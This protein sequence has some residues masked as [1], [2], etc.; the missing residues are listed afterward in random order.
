MATFDFAN[1]IP[2]RTSGLLLAQILN[3][4]FAAEKSGYS[5]GDDSRA[6]LTY[7]AGKVWYNNQQAAAGVLYMKG[8]GNDSLPLFKANLNTRQ[9]RTVNDAAL[10]SGWQSVRNGEAEYVSADTRAFSV[11]ADGIAFGSR[12]AEYTIDARGRTDCFV[13]PTRASNFSFI[14]GGLAYNG[15]DN[16]LEV[17]TGGSNTRKVAFQ[18]ELGASTPASAALA[19]LTPAANRIPRFTSG[20]GADLV[21]F[22]TDGTFVSNSDSALVSERAINTRIGAATA[23]LI[24][25][26]TANESDI[27]TLETSTAALGVKRGAA[28]SLS[29][30]QLTGN[31]TASWTGIPSGVRR[32]EIALDQ[33]SLSSSEYILVQIGG[34]SYDTSGYTSRTERLGES[35]SVG[36][37][38]G[39]VLA[40]DGTAG[41]SGIVTLINVTGN[42]WVM[43]ATIFRDDAGPSFSAG[44]K[45]LSATL[46]RI[47]IGP[48]SGTF[49]GGQANALWME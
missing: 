46:D 11:N 16:R 37:T 3:N 15:T 27:S 24:T 25:R 35:G 32:I 42:I 1:I 28:V 41:R 33:A 2:S 14:E 23:P 34:G 30:K 20:T 29:G 21:E 4:L 49:A 44:R 39:F 26:L 10:R 31:S 38:A 8:D 12:E 9:L 40:Q 22:S 48:E 19:S 13:L 17:G 36:R 43:T 45:G 6:R 7:S 5:A 47:R 18:D